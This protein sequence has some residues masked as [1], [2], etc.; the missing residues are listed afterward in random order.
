[1]GASRILIVTNDCA[2]AERAANDFKAAGFIFVDVVSSNL[3]EVDKELDRRPDLMLIDTECVRDV[4]E[5]IAHVRSVSDIPILSLTGLSIHVPNADAVPVDATVEDRLH[6]TQVRKGEGNDPSA[7]MTVRSGSVDLKRHEELESLVRDRAEELIETNRRLQQEIAERTQ[8]EKSLAA[9]LTKFRALYEVAVAMTANRSLDEN[10]SLVVEKSRELLQG[11][12]SYIALRDESGGHVYMHTLSGIRTEAFKK[13]ILPL[14]KGLGGQVAHSGKGLIVED[15]FKETA[16]V[17]HDAVKQEGLISG[18]AVPIQM[19]K[20]NLGVLYVFN[21]SRTLFST[22]DLDTLALMGNLAALEITRKRV[23]LALQRSRTQLEERVEQRTRDLKSANEKFVLQFAE[24]RKAEKA[25]LESERMLKR[26]LAA[27][28]LGIAYFEQTK[29]RWTNEAMKKMFGH[30]HE[31]DY[32]NRHP[33][34]FYESFDEYKLLKKRFLESAGVGKPLE[35]EVRL[36]RADGSTFVGQL[37]ISALDYADPVKGTISTVSDITEKKNAEEATRES[38]ERYRSLV[39]E[40]FDGIFVRK[41]PRI[42]FANTRLYE[43]LG[44]EDGGLEG[45]IHW[46]MYHPDYQETAKKRAAARAS[47]IDLDPQHEVRLLRKDGSSFEAEIRARVITFGSESGMQVW[48]RDISER[49]RAE[50][51]LRES[52]EKYRTIIDNIE[53]VY[54]EV[55]LSGRWVFLNDAARN[56]FGRDKEELLGRKYSEFLT[57]ENSAKLREVFNEV[58]KSGVAVKDY[59]WKMI[60]PDAT[61]RHLEFSISLMKGAAGRASGFRGI[62]RDVTGRK[63]AEQELLKLEKIESIGVLAGGI[64][65]DFNNILTAVQGN[66]SLAKLLQDPD[67]KALHRLSEAEKACVRARDLTQQ[68]LTFSKGGAPIKKTASIA[69]V[70]SDACSFALRGS[71]VRCEFAISEQLRTVEIDEVQIGRVIG[72]MVINADQA[73]PD[74]GLILIGAENVSVSPQQNL[75]LEPG[76]YVRISIED[77]GQGI[78]ERILPKVFDPYFTTKSEGSG[79]GLATAY[80]IVKGHGGHITV[81]SELGMGT[82]FHLFLPASDRAT[83]PRMSTEERV[84]SGSGKILIMDDEDQ[85]RDLAG[86]LLHLLGYEVD[87][88]RDGEEAIDLFKSAKASGKVYDAVILDVTVPGG[89]GGREVIRHL[90][91]IDGNVKAIV[92]SGYSHDPIMADYERYGFSGVIPKPYNARQLSEILSKVIEK[93]RRN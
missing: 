41:G 78:D 28:P 24:L 30:T 58:Y 34:E 40:S 8:A 73:M 56:I 50:E 35:A 20:D 14:G 26:I 43:M 12:T 38:E 81:E 91:A 4:A 5:I 6:E 32:M 49:K 77:H 27:S 83:F 53:A 18:V 89:M 31:D 51:A 69:E 42:V 46:L 75:P 33:G 85:I 66:V 72:N 67:S 79:L 15:Y 10:L 17:V 92:S 86:E 48:V 13:L 23:E 65:H 68:L 29:L 62:C 71:N 3:P 1:M 87:T 93:D 39:E 47:G 55:S 54:Y 16:P 57:E 11:D 37:R 36:K 44:Y 61:E 84:M 88:A 60:N 9:E 76:H 19:G 7:G 59:S 45:M 2:G 25:L 63:R 22:S 64:A 70:L 82:T 80:S 21:R 74:G 90:R 52:E